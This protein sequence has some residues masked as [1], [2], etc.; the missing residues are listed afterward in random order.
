MIISKTSVGSPVKIIDFDPPKLQLRPSPQAT[1]YFETRGDTPQDARPCL[2]ALS[3]LSIREAMA[4][5]IGKMMIKQRIQAY[6][7]FSEKPR[8][9]VETLTSKASINGYK[10]GPILEQNDA[11]GLKCL[12]ILLSTRSPS[13][14]Q[15][16][17]TNSRPTL[18]LHR[19]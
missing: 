10:R 9:F 7:L 5:F 13:R 19:R 18:H 16:G 11:S 8:L 1:K 2:N 6:T 3:N 4:I 12:R 17:L 14:L 15:T